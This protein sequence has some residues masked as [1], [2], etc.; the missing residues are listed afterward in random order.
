MKYQTTVE[1]NKKFVVRFLHYDCRTMCGTVWNRSW[2][3]VTK[4]RL[5][6]V[7]PCA[8]VRG[9]WLSFIRNDFFVWGD[10]SVCLCK[11]YLSSYKIAFFRYL[12]LYSGLHESSLCSSIPFCLPKACFNHMAM[13]QLIIAL[14]SRLPIKRLHERINDGCV[15][16]MYSEYYRMVRKRSVFQFF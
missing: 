15:E 10:R 2:T 16:C 6:F 9:L 1:V 3:L 8:I 7:L 12:L 14:R 11:T 5:N 4:K 13:K